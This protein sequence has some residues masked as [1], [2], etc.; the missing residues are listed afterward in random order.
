MI[1]ILMLPFIVGTFYIFAYR[2]NT[3]WLRKQNPKQ[4]H[5]MDEVVKIVD[6]PTKLLEYDC[7]MTEML[8][9]A[10]TEIIQS[11]TIRQTKVFSVILLIGYVIYF[12]VA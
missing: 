5:Q 1:A 3:K 7:S 4:F 2:R 12:V 10:K 11:K 8:N 9:R 6:N